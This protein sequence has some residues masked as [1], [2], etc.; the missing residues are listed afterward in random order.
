DL[1]AVL[2]VLLPVL[3]AIP[4]GVV[5]TFLPAGHKLVWIGLLVVLTLALV[6]VT[7]VSQRQGSQV[8]PGAGWQM[9]P[10]PAGWVDRAEGA[11]AGAAVSA[12]DG[13]PVALTTG[14]AGAGGFGKT[15]LAAKACHDRAVRRR[16]KT[17]VWVTVGRDLDEPAL[18]ARISEVL[19]NLGEDGAAF[20]TGEEAGP[21]LTGALG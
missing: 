8:P 5:I 16:F 21:A 19:R 18:A 15:T 7:I 9:P 14:L 11:A 4:A 6:A 20:T 13:A 10:A 17:G 12:A 3:I 1:V 2:L